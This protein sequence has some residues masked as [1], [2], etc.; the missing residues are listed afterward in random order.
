MKSHNALFNSSFVVLLIWFISTVDLQAAD[1]V[2]SAGEMLTYVLPIAAGGL[3][4]GYKDREGAL[5]FVES[6]ALAF[7]VT[8]VLKYTVDETRPNGDKYS[9]PS[10]HTS[11]SFASAEF[12]RKRYG[13][14]YGIPAYGIAGFVAY[15]RVE[16]RQHYIHDVLA[17]AVIGIGS[18]YLFTKPY[19]GW[20]LKVEAV[21]RYYG[22]CFSHAW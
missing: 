21:S 10:G 20:Y 22:I 18:N 9:F 12:I 8:R 19:K 3:L 16:A 14:E 5:Q 1:R 4:I 17:G 7:G 13:W 11:A 2:E 6:N 15:S